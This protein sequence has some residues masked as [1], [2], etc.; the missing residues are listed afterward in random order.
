M[1]KNEGKSTAEQME[2]AV[3]AE[4]SETVEDQAAQIGS[5]PTVEPAVQQNKQ[6]SVSAEPK[7]DPAPDTPKRP[8]MVVADPRGLNLRKG[9]HVSYDAITV[10]SDSTPVEIL[11]L[12]KDVEVPNW[13][14]VKTCAGIGWVNINFLKEA[15]P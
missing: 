9:P 8:E 2:Q 4:T 5:E 6:S 13:A 14:L 12:P 3:P 7:E 15:E 1:S 10:L 11:N